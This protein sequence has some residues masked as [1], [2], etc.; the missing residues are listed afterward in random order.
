MD[1]DARKALADVGITGDEMTMGLLAAR[2]ERGEVTAQ[3]LAETMESDFLRDH[4]QIIHVRLPG[5]VA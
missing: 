3:E 4:V 5:K 1:T 2:I